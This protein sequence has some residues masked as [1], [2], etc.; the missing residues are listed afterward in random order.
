MRE[1]SN[2]RPAT[3]HRG[4]GGDPRDR[5]QLS[6]A[7]PAADI[8]VQPTLRFVTAFLVIGDE[9][10]KRGGEGNKVASHTD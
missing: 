1:S 10:G 3:L 2:E 6:Y 9:T 8:V 7:G 5:A 4:F